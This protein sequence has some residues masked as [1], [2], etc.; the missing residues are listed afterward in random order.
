[1]TGLFTNINREVSIAPLAT[2]RALFGL[3]MLI[4]I[5]RF[6]ARGWIDQ[7]YIQPDFF[8]T[9]P[10]FAWIQPPGQAGT[11]ILFALMTLGAAGIMLGWRYRLTSVLFFSTFTYVELI[12]KTNYLNHYYF[13]SIIAFLLML[14]PAHR[15]FSLDARRRPEIELLKVPSW[16]VSIFKLQLGMVYFFAGIAKINPDWL[17]RAMPLRSGLREKPTYLLSATEEGEEEKGEE[18]LKGHKSPQ[19]CY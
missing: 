13:V 11:Y 1:M 19:K 5:A 4:S 17:F 2:F 7:L 18:R 6:A 14:V 3:V 8:F 12:D 16:M 15:H 10:G 9:Y